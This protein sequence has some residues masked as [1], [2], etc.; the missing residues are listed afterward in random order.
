MVSEKLKHEEG[1]QA[2]VLLTD[3]YDEHSTLGADEALE[4]IKGLHAPLYVIGIAGS[5]GISLKGEQFLREIA[6]ATGGRAY[7]P[8]RDWQYDAMNGKV[9][10]EV[11]QRY[12][13]AY[14]P[15][16]QKIDGAWRRIDLKTPR[17]EWT[18]R[19]RSGYFAPKPPPVRP[20]LE[21]TMMNR[22]R[23]L[24][25]VSV[26]DLQVR[27]NGV[28]QT[29]ETFE[30]AVSPVSMVLAL[31]GSGSMKKQAAAAQ[32]AARS[33]V[34]AIRPEDKLSVASF[35]DRVWFHHG[36]ATDRDWSRRAIDQYI[37]RGGTALYDALYESLVRLRTVSG[38]RVAI[39]V[40]DG[41]DENNPGTAP[42][43][44]HGFEEVLELMKQ[45]DVTVFAIGLGP[46]VDREVLERIAAESGGES[47][48]PLDVSELEDQYRRVVENLR[49]RYVI[50]Y[51]ST[52][53]TRDGAWRPVEIAS[54]IPGTVVISKGGYF[55]PPE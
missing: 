43:S 54:R 16:N 19:S 3:G 6:K 12:V 17:P 46:N 25:A 55:A 51:T 53:P 44:V 28:E 5:A 29:L 40:T 20:S 10:E 7:F 34:E 41:R 2:I 13:I 38:R 21:F 27:E 33:F 24:L 15:S 42:G 48:F 1:R 8:T 50:S 22:E 47:Y 11:Q 45:A 26:E 36:F 4:I 23:E 18:I 31:D 52:D 35:A 37:T 9:A 32:A 14:T 30:E 39:L 49:R